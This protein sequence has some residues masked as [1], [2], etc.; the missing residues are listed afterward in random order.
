M[1]YLN[2]ESPRVS[3]VRIFENQRID[4]YQIMLNVIPYFNGSKGK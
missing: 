2:N 4:Q 1:D 3:K